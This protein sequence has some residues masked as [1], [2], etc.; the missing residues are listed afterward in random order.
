M[1]HI[2]I[3]FC[4]VTLFLVTQLTLAQTGDI[5][6]F[7]YEKESGEPVIFTNVILEGTSYGAATD[8]N[9][10]YSINRIPVGDYNIVCTSIGFDTTRVAISLKDGEIKNQKLYLSESDIVLDAVEINVEKEEAQS[11]V[12][13]S[14]IKISSK[15]ISKIPAI[16]GEPDLAQYLQV[17]PGVVF[18]GDQGGQLYIRGGS[19]IQTKVLL[20]GM[21]I[22]NPFH[23]IGLFSVFETDLIRNVDVITGGFNAT[24]G[25]RT[26]AIIDI[27]MRDGNKKRHTGKV[28][29]NTFLTKAYLEGP[30]SRLD[31]DG[32]GLSASYV[33]S[34]KT[35]YLDRTS[36]ILY[37]YVDDATREGET[38][39][40][41]PYSFTDFYGKVSLNTATGSKLNFSG[42]RFGDQ[43]SFQGKSEYG[44]ESFGLGSTF[45]L[46]PGSSKTL[47]NGYFNYS[48]YSL[49][50]D[51]G[52]GQPRSTSIGGFNGGVNFSYFLP[53]GDIKYGIEL[54]GFETTFEF[55]NPLGVKLE[56]NQ[57]T[58]E[59]GGFVKYKAQLL[60]NK[61][62]VE[63]SVRINYYATLPQ[64]TLEPR[65]GLKYNVNSDLRLKLSTGI[66]TQN[67]VSTK[68]DRDVVNLFTGFLSTPENVETVMGEPVEKRLQSAFHAIT[69]VEMNLTKKLDFNTEIYYK[70]FDPLVN[71]NRNKTFPTDP[72]YIVETGNAYGWDFLIKYDYKRFFAWAVYSLSFVDRNDGLQTY[73]PHFDRRHNVNFLASYKF[74][75]NLD[76]EASARWNFGSGFPFTKTQGFYEKLGLL[77]GGIDSDYVSSEGELG[78]IY[79]DQ[80]NGGRLPTYHRFDLS[81]KKQIAIGANSILEANASVTNIYNRENIFYFD[82]VRYERVNQLPILPSAGLSMTF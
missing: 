33:L 47:I 42:F 5:R 80:L 74:G 79:D 12:R 81:V 23:S 57:Y 48:S 40:A 61:L 4:F 32:N 51:E 16:G 8:I 21:T 14:T 39:D 45:V 66:Y 37:S 62:L 41:L 75:R 17:L 9:G 1:Q 78:L 56:E 52:D 68:S 6:G 35:S 55:F 34:A 27:T 63:P 71:L 38:N 28:A 3:L 50:L 64:F 10:F 43:A 22:Y 58:T 46:V 44:W 7:V 77:D 49:E 65:L 18:T 69:G 19:Q 59:I 15:Q 20:D 2:K 82:R 30:I 13:I 26:S 76:W 29:A 67:F 70:R 24:Y 31:D 72:N 60:D 25:G 36:P 54:S 73:R 11:E 53:K